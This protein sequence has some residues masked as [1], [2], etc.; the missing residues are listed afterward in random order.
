MSEHEQHYES[1][2][3]RRIERHLVEILARLDRVDHANLGLRR[4]FHAHRK[5]M[6]SF[7][8]DIKAAV[9]TL[10]TQVASTED[11]VA[12]AIHLLKQLAESGDS[13]AAAEIEALTAKLKTS[14]DALNVA[15]AENTPQV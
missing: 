2:K 10:K 9:E 6:E 14:A 4:D 15:V 7:M 13:E 1:D 5:E 3:D 11:A 12:T 8:S